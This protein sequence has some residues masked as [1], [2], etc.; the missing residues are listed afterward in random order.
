MFRSGRALR[1]KLLVDRERFQVGVF[2]GNRRAH[3]VAVAVVRRRRPDEVHALGFRQP[4]RRRD[5]R[6]AR[7]IVGGAVGGVLL[8]LDLRR[9]R[10][11]REHRLQRRVRRLRR[12]EL[13]RSPP[14]RR[15][16]RARARFET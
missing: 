2:S 10:R 4:R 9:R 5:A 13:S 14:T 11:D 12:V 6:V 1:S 16:A 8:A 15:R 3:R 7:V